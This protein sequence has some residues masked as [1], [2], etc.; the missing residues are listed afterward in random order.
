MIFTV[1]TPLEES[2]G[3]LSCDIVT[4]F[5]EAE[6]YEYHKK[7]RETGN[8]SLTVPDDTNGIDRVTPDM[9]LFVDEGGNGNINDCLIINDVLREGKHIT[10]SGTDLKGL[11]G[12]RV[13]L[14]PQ[15]E[16]EAGTYGYDARSGTTGAI[17][18]GFITYNCINY[19]EPERNIPGLTIGNTSGGLADD[20]YMSRLQPLDEVVNDICRNADVGWDITFSPS[21]VGSGYE[22]RLIEGTDRT[23]ATG[24]RKC[25]FASFLCNVETISKQDKTSERRNVIWTV[26]G[27]DVE[28][29]VVTSVVT[30]ADQD[31]ASGF[32]RREAVMTASCDQD[33]VESYVKSKSTDM[34]NKSELKFELAD[35]Q[36][37]GSM[38]EVGDKVSV[39][40]SGVI[41]DKRVME[42]IKNYSAGKRAIDVQIADIP[43]KK[44]FERNA[45]VMSARADDVKELALET[46][47]VKNRQYKT[48]YAVT[49]PCNDENVT[50]NI[51]DH[52]VKIDNENDRNIVTEYRRDKV[53]TPTRSST[54]PTEQ[55]TPVYN[56]SAGGSGGVGENVGNHNE[57]FN[58]YTAADGCTISGASYHDYNHAEGYK[59]ILSACMYTHVSGDENEIIS[60]D[61]AWICGYKNKKTGA[62]DSR[63]FTLAGS[64]NEITAG[65]SQSFLAGS[66]NKVY[67]TS[68]NCIIVGASN[69]ALGYSNNYC[70]IVAGNAN[71]ITDCQSSIVCGQLNDVSGS[72]NACFGGHNKL[73][74][75]G[76]LALG[77]G[78]DTTNLNNRTRLV[79][80]SG[81]GNAIYATSNGDFYA[82]GGYNTMSADYADLFEWADG[83]PD[84][85]DRR[86]MLVALDGD[87]I[88]P[89]QGNNIYGIIS[90]N[91]S[92]IGNNPIEWHGKYKKDVFGSVIKDE[93]G[94]PILSEEYDPNK[95]YELRSERPEWSPLG[96]VGRLIIVDNGSCE[97]NGY[98]SARNGIGTASL[99]TTNIRVLKRIDDNHVEVF[100]R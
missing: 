42:V 52:W 100:I 78:A 97:P 27:S 99:S 40:E 9:I 59:N 63:G 41:Y 87:K 13:T 91:P 25:V 67:T 56:V 64:A 70:C 35:P 3:S 33:L 83:N 7:W 74:K 80:G 46:A 31:E 39:M 66:Y 76:C 24:E 29:A 79:I 51:G 55:W 34:V 75:D 98:V 26:N 43:V 36:M 93:N 4:G 94:E 2:G 23:N 11:L 15:N 61:S 14:F 5:M 19:P 62:V 22:F 89:A 72:Q 96:L 65:I 32:L 49:D 68:T 17:I 84:N 16:I 54:A 95:K 90:A 1:Y 6:R 37:Y 81:N 12:Y 21:T 20:A 48:L 73:T 47:N 38:F 86:G 57:R 45:A 50:V 58:G 69:Q 85:E 8:F 82:T 60:A 92:I 71:K 44:Y 53:E 30:T 28:K 88:I 10:L 18:S 77:Y